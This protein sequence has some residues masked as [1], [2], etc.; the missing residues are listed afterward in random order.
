MKYRVLWAMDLEGDTP[1]HAAQEAL[2]YITKAQIFTVYEEADHST[3]GGDKEVR[4][5]FQVNLLDAS[6]EEIVQ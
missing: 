1:L 3:N 2:G 6:V 5:I 4:K